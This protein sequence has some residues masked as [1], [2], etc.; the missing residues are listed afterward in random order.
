MLYFEASAKSNSNIQEMLFT[1][2]SKLPF[3]DNIPEEEKADL[4]K[5]L[6]T[7]NANFEKKVETDSIGVIIK[8]DYN[9]PE[10]ATPTPEKNSCCTI[11]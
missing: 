5:N 9:K 4:V 8:G 11:F 2:V 7:E 10:T 6:I 3:F 1:C